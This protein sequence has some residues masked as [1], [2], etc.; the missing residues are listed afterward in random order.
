M[1]NGLW[2]PKPGNSKKLSSKSKR[3]Q[4][5]EESTGKVVDITKSESDEVDPPSK[6]IQ[7]EEMD[8]VTQTKDDPSPVIDVERVG[9]TSVGVN[10]PQPDYQSIDAMCITDEETRTAAKTLKSFREAE[11]PAVIDSTRTLPGEEAHFK[12]TGL[13]DNI[14]NSTRRQK[15]F[16]SHLIMQQM[17]VNTPASSITAVPIQYVPW[18]KVI[19]GDL[20]NLQSRWTLYSSSFSFFN[21]LSLTINSSYGTTA[22]DWYSYSI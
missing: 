12:G 10:M 11:D 9:T 1:L 7:D 13:M 17:A 4:R 20:I 8:M 15:K 16:Y 14:R 19:T 5:T 18:A 6:Q 3:S 22:H 21:I 2:V